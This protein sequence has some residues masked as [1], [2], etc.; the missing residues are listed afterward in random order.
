MILDITYGYTV[1]GVDDP[2]VHLADEAA[3][4]S[5]RYS[6]TGATICDILPICEELSPF[7]LLAC[8]P[9]ATKS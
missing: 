1:E 4:E 3:F 2:F 7:P 8:Q 9:D 6:A 5:L